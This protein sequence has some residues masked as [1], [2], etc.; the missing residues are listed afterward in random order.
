MFRH[1]SESIVALDLKIS[2]LFWS[3]YTIDIGGL[4]IDVDRNIY[5]AFPAKKGRDRTKEFMIASGY[6]G[7][8]AEHAI[9]EQLFDIPAV[10]TVKI[11][12]VANTQGIPIYTI[13]SDNV[14]KILPK[15]QVSESVKDSIRNAVNAGRIIVIPERNVEFYNWTGVGYIVLDPETGAGAYMISGG[16]AGGYG[17][18]LLDC[19][20]SIV[21]AAAVL[22]GYIKLEILAFFATLH[23]IYQAKL[24]KYTGLA[25]ILL[26]VMALGF[27]LLFAYVSSEASLLSAAGI[28]AF[29]LG[30]I[31]GVTFLWM[32]A[33]ITGNGWD[34]FTKACME[35]Y[36]RI[37]S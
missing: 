12:Q 9:L 25:A 5:S 30:A 1:P 19:I 33:V 11:L 20:E 2:Y 18:L 7:S 26:A 31:Y 8:M 32:I 35:I 21:E 23:D 4:G 36:N 34:S 3:P 37:V 16:L 13:N 6:I 22:V 14:D 10:S 15:L 29:I 17:A 24:D 28:V 27:G